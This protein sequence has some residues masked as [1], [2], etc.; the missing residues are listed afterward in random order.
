[1]KARQGEVMK[2]EKYYSECC[3]VLMPDYPD[4]DFC[5]ECKEHTSGFTRAEIEAE[6]GEDGRLLK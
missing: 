4:S 6:E 3:D 1:M 5:P 2:T